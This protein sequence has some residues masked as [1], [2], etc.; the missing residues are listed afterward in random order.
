MMNF[1]ADGFV[2]A[3]DMRGRPAVLS[4]AG[5]PRGM[6]DAERRRRLLRAAEQVFLVKGYVST[7]MA[8]I[9]ALAAMSKKTLYQVFESKQALFDTL[10]IE[11]IARLSLPEVGAGTAPW[12]ELAAALLAYGR[13]LLSRDQVILTRLILA[14]IASVPDADARVGQLCGQAEREV[15]QWLAGQAAGGWITIRDPAAAAETIFALAFGPL[16]TGLLLDLA[17][18]PTE[19]ELAA[20]IDRSIRV[21]RREFAA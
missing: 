19:D 4:R 16:Q 10:M 2:S 11:R 13:R 5:A 9:A 6:D 14:N 21:C 17:E 12:A 18:E 3:A 15:A 20:R 8:D 7:T 1:A